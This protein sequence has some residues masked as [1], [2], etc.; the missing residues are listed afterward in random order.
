MLDFLNENNLFLEMHQGFRPGRSCKHADDAN[1][2]VTA[3]SIHDLVKWVNLNGLALNLKNAK[4]MVF[5]RQFIDFS[6]T[7]LIIDNRKIR[8]PL[9][10]SNNE[11]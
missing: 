4:Y 9:L 2:V 5:A 8:M 7:E 1:I 10:K 6:G 11:R 3:S